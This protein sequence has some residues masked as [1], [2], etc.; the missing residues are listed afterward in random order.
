M[1]TPCP[2]QDALLR[3][4]DGE[5]TEN[6]AARLRAHAAGCPPCA[7]ALRA[8][9]RLVARLAAPLPELATAGAVAEVM[10]RLDAGA[11]APPPRRPRPL[12][13]PAWASGVAALAAAAVLVV[14]LPPAAQRTDG[15]T[16]RGGAAP[17]TSQVGV[18]LWAL[19]D[20]PR[21]L[22]PGDG[23]APGVPVV[24][25]VRNAGPAAAWL[26]AYALDARGEVHW[27]YPGYLDPATDPE[28]LRLDGRQAQRTLPEAVVLEGVPAGAL[29]LVTV[30]SPGPRRVSE[31]ERAAPAERTPEALRRR[32]P[33][34]RVDE[35][36]LRYA[37]GEG[38]P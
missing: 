25:S 4:V 2:S 14:A 13:P 28:A 8:Q 6:E 12:G 18:E 21:R 11:A 24:A 37:A 15:F 19:R 33:E 35:V 26:L 29:R 17:W 22:A 38:R 36:P 10:R 27:L 3:L 20:Q 30:L 31:I 32:W 5:L 7:R 1:S 16:A 34:A 23:L 9:E